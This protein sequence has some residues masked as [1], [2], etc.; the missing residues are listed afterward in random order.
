MLA[1]DV[2]A[3]AAVFA[4]I[5][6]VPYL[7]LRLDVITSNSCRKFHIDPV[8]AQLVCTYRG[9]GIKYGVSTNGS[10]PDKVLIVPTCA[11]IVMRGTNWPEHPKSGFLHQSPAVEGTGETRLV[12]K[13][14]P[15]TEDGSQ[16]EP[17][18]STLH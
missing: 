13:L 10:D 3:L 11:P 14:D 8:T 7:R 5:M 4:K 15:V 1:D 18:H 6:R 12:L 9:T 2:A 17:S 16:P